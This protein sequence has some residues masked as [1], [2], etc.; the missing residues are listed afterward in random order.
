MFKILVPVDFSDFSSQAVEHA[1]REA[2]AFGGQVTLLYVIHNVPRL[3]YFGGLDDTSMAHMVETEREH[4]IKLLKE[5][6]SRFDGTQAEV[7]TLILEGEPAEKIIDYSEE[8]PVDLIVMG[9]Q[10]IGSPMRRV[11]LGSVA[12]RVLHHVKVPVLVVR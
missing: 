11:F 6:K 1:K 8:N 5:Y 7:D 2:I 9:S 4:A 10:G 3:Y 12:N